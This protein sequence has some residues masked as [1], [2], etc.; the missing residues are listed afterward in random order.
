MS[1][2]ASQFARHHDEAWPMSFL[3][4]CSISL[5][6]RGPFICT[7][8]FCSFTPGV[9]TLGTISLRVSARPLL[10]LK[11]LARAINPPSPREKERERIHATENGHDSRGFKKRKR[12]ICTFGVCPRR[13][14]PGIYLVFKI[15]QKSGGNLDVNG[16]R[17]SG[18]IFRLKKFSCEKLKN[19]ES[20]KKLNL[21][22]QVLNKYLNNISLS[23]WY[24]PCVY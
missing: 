18:K 3:L 12:G 8:R 22:W 11:L 10:F 20:E 23:V 14:A 21:I 7:P 1:L 24:V 17:F 9:F 13:S 4:L 6:A 2:L 15:K 16:W 19:L 5:A